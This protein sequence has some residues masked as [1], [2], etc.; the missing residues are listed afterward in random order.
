MSDI[1]VLNGLSIFMA[2]TCTFY[3]DVLTRWVVYID[4]QRTNKPQRTKE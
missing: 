4:E 1:L 2:K 3:T